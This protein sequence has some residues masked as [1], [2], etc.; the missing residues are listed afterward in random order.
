MKSIITKYLIL[1]LLLATFAMAGTAQ[2]YQKQIGMRFGNTTGFTARIIKDEVFAME[3][4]LGFRNHGMQLYLLAESRK[5]VFENKLENMHMYFG[6]GAHIGF[7]KWSDYP[8]DPYY[9]PDYDYN[10]N[11]NHTGPALGIDG[12]IGLEYGFNSVPITLGVDFKPFLE[13][14]GPWMVRA[15]FWDFGFQISY[16]F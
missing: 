14:Y 8:Y 9:D 12:I 15:N 2:E 7:V 16:N 5:P 13:I 10:P 4:I 3:G 6:G 1:I 11:Y